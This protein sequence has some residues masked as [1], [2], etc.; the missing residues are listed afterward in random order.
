LDE[1]NSEELKFEKT[2]EQGLKLFDKITKSCEGVISGK[3]VFLLFQSYG[4]PLEMTVIA[5]LS[6]GILSTLV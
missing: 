3:N 6:R 5:Y 2:L 4:F 1:I